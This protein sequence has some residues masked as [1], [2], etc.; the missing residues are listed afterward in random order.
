MQCNVSYLIQSIVNNTDLSLCR[1]RGAASEK[2]VQFSAKNGLELVE[3]QGVE[4][5]GG[6]VLLVPLELVFITQVEHLLKGRALAFNCL[7][8]VLNNQRC[9]VFF[10]LLC[11]P[12]VS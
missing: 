7:E 2:E 6:V 9:L 3:H 5:G 11:S 12:S 4:D 8:E 1:Q 10:I